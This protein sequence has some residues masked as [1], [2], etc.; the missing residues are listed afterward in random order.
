M[1][2]GTVATYTSTNTNKRRQRPLIKRKSPLISINLRRSIQRARILLRSLQPNLDDI[3]YASQSAS[4]LII[5]FRFIFQAYRTV[6]LVVHISICKLT[7]PISVSGIKEYVYQVRPVQHPQL[8]QQKGPSTSF[9]VLGLGARARALRNSFL[10][11]LTLSLSFASGFPPLI[12]DQS[13]TKSGRFR[14]AAN[15]R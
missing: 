12:E 9:L 2:A 10:R 14:D 15:A 1:I 4:P 5:N 11:L 8:H 3:F 7:T 6:D 13:P